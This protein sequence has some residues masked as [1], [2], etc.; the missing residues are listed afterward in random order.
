MSDDQQ[1]TEELQHVNPASVEEV[2]VEKALAE[3]PTGT[4]ADKAAAFFQR[5]VDDLK[6]HVDRMSMRAL[7]RMILY[8]ATYPFLGKEYKL[9]VGSPEYKAAYR[10]NEMITQKVLMQLQF[11]H[12]KAVKA[13]EDG[14]VNSENQLTLNKGETTSDTKE[15]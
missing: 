6:V 12:E 8:Q 14:K 2:M 5:S 13:M 9:K 3:D 7:K 10:F 11:E 1:Q 15:K 4:P